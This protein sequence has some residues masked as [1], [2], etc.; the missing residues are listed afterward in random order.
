VREA[1][2]QEHALA[3][4]ATGPEPD[5]TATDAQAI[6]CALDKLESRA[7]EVLVLFF[8]ESMSLEEIAEVVGRPVG[9][10]KSRLHYA[11]R[12]LHG[13]LKR[14]GYGPV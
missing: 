11:K 5:F 13:L 8:L 1:A 14:D 2:E 12:A 6:H 4:D 7:R 10:V 9:T 3:A